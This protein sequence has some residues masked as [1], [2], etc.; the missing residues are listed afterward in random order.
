MSTNEVSDIHKANVALQSSQEF[1]GP[2]PIKAYIT[3]ESTKCGPAVMGMIGKLLQNAGATV[4]V[5]DERVSLPN[6]TPKLEGLHISL[7]RVVWAVDKYDSPFLLEQQIHHA[8]LRAALLHGLVHA[9][10]DGLLGGW[11]HAQGELL[12]LFVGSADFL[13]LGHIVLATRFVAC[14]Q[15]HLPERHG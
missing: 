5:E 14:R 12:P 6:F 15:D 9:G 1:R 11:K 7:G 10:V 2:A 4:T 8:A 13:F 3:L